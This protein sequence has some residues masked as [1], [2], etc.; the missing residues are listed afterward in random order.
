MR[1]EER[2]STMAAKLSVVAVAVLA[3]AGIAYFMM[4]EKPPANLRDL[5][6]TIPPAVVETPKAA[7]KPA[8]QNLFVQL[9]RNL[10]LL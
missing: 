5:P 10:Y 2:S 9:A 4:K 3:I 8:T 6:V 1:Y 7:E